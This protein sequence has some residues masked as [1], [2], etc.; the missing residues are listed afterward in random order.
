[1]TTR[2]TT[3]GQTLA[4]ALRANFGIGTR[5]RRYGQVF[6]QR[7]DLHDAMVEAIENAVQYPGYY[8]AEKTE[9]LRSAWG[10][11][12]SYRKHYDGYRMD[13][14]LRLRI[15]QLTAYQF[16]ALL[17]RM[18]DAGVQTTGGGEL[19]FADMAHEQTT[20]R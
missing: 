3:T 20:R 5:T 9:I 8:S 14:V 13:S 2:A 11:A 4:A 17:G 16:A 15:S 1:M 12:L 6:G 18:V 10:A 7:T 19:F